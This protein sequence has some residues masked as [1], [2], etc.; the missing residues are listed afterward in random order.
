MTRQTVEIESL[1]EF[2]SHIDRTKALSGWF[3]QSIDLTD[4]ADVLASVDPVGAVFLGCDLTEPAAEDLRARGALLFPRL[5]DLPF[6][7]Y[8]ST[9]YDATELFGP[10]PYSEGADAVIYAW[11]RG[12]R[13]LAR[14]L[15]ISLHD[16]AIGDALD[17]ATAGFDPK[18]F[19]GVMGG[20]DLLRGSEAYAEAAR[21]GLRL[22]R[23][24]RTVL[25][26]G[27]PGAMEAANLGAWM[28][29][30]PDELDVAL[31]IL[32]DVPSFRPSLDDWARTAM[33][34]LHRWPDGGVSIG[35]PTW[36]YGH[37]PPNA[38]ASAIAKYFTNALREDTLISRCRGGIVYLAGAAGT[39]QEI[40]QASTENYYAADDSVV[41][42]MIL[43]GRDYWTEQ[44]PAWPLLT[45]LGKDRHMGLKISL[46]DSADKA[47]DLLIQMSSSGSSPG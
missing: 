45:S 42:P 35:I 19:V 37:E 22:T 41:A 9:L 1:E 10:G 28:S 47:A 8:R 32:A 30:H 31:G 7:P 27:G 34:V 24:G 6:D 25:T 13:S 23:A 36:F 15:A 46:V 2:D 44:L 39:V 5:P 40:F 18:G 29:T 43:V 20:H 33:E 26:G 12:D 38:F 17:E 21:L 4:R 3:V 14:T 11:S 16:H